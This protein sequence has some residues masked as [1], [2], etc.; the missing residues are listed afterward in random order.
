[1]SEGKNEFE[2]D[3]SQNIYRLSN[4]LDAILFQLQNDIGDFFKE[5]PEENGYIKEFVED[6]GVIENAQNCL[7]RLPDNQGKSQIL[8]SLK[9][10]RADDDKIIMAHK[11]MTD[12]EIVEYFPLFLKQVY[13]KEQMLEW[14]QEA[15][16]DREYDQ[17][18]NSV[19]DILYFL[20]NDIISNFLNNF[21]ENNEYIADFIEKGGIIEDAKNCVVKFPSGNRYQISIVFHDVDETHP[22]IVIPEKL[23]NDSD[24]DFLNILIQEMG[25]PR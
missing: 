13:K 6:G 19:D 10:F 17:F 7:I 5:S 20:Q 16:Y 22:L 8:L 25:N 21:P 3:Y 4:S 1:M 11:D 24:Y 2:G 9:K 15:K 23:Y 14:M 12:E 18:D